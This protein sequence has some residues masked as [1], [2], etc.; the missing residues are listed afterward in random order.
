M[1]LKAGLRVQ[2]SV[3]LLMT[4]VY[5]AGILKYKRLKN[6]INQSYTIAEL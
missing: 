4:K 5:K 3:N 6:I 2:I 1:Q